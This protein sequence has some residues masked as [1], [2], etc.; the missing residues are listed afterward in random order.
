[1][2]LNG[3]CAVVTGAGRGIG[4]AIALGL[5]QR[6]A[7]VAV[8]DIDP[9]TAKAVAGEIGTAGGQAIDVACDV[10]DVEAI[11]AAFENAVERLGDLDILVNAAGIQTTTSC[12][13][14]TPENWD[15]QMDVNLRGVFFCCQ[16]AARVMI[17]KR[18]GKIVNIAS[19]SAFVSS[20]NAK[21]AY[22]SSKGGVR[23]MTVALG[24]E[25]SRH[26]INVNAVAPGTMMTEMTRPILSTPEQQASALARI[27]LGRIGET[28]DVVGPVCFL[29]S[30]EAAYVVGHTLVVDGGWIL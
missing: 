18:E 13:D 7:K 28:E 30:D 11:R 24:V 17:P 16:A 6:G 9:E 8:L 14:Y 2:T 20:R 12:L 5:A 3:K 4:R 29:A 23:Q 26:G 15:R 10:G 25:L 21:A 22:D 1:M 19:T 27:P